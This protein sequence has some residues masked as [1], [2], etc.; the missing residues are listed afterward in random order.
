M[1][2]VKP[3]TREFFINHIAIWLPEY[4]YRE[5]S[6]LHMESCGK[7]SFF[8]DYENGVFLIRDNETK[9]FVVMVNIATGETKVENA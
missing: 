3:S 1:I 6:I 5:L 9:K 4:I 8:Q 2:E 7:I